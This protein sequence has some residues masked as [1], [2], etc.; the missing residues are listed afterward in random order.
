[1]HH[2]DYVCICISY[3][4]S[5]LSCPLPFFVVWVVVTVCQLRRWVWKVGRK[6]SDSLSRVN[7][8]FLMSGGWQDWGGTG[9]KGRM[10]LWRNG[11]GP[12]AVTRN[13]IFAKHELSGLK[14]AKIRWIYV[15]MISANTW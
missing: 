6:K 11:S 15:Y 8:P 1:L 2:H 9:N 5:V 7:H 3:V 12:P 4:S 10:D 13:C 14:R